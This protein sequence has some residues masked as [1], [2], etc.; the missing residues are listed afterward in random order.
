[1]APASAQES[2]SSEITHPVSASANDSAAATTDVVVDEEAG[3]V[4][5]LI[6]G[7]EMVLI[8][9]EGLHVKGDVSFNGML[10]DTGGRAEPDDAP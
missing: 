5:V 1:M 8:D 7:R 10:V 9:H 4:R 2:P 6:N 3:T